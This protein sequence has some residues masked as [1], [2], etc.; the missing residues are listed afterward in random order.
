MSKGK[1]V[2][3]ALEITFKATW[4]FIF[5]FV[6]SF[7]GIRLRAQDETAKPPAEP[8]VI[9]VFPLGGQQGT[10]VEVE[11][12][13]RTLQGAYAIS[14]D[15]KGLKAQV[16]KVEEIELG[17][18]RGK[19]IES[20]K[21]P[22]GHRVL[23]RMQISPEARIG[24]YALW[25]IAARGVSNAV[26]FW[27][28]G[29]P[30]VVEGQEPNGTPEQAQALRLP[31][32]VNGKI[33]Q[34]GELDY[35]RF[36][37]TA[38]QEVVF[39]LISEM[40]I[41]SQLAL[42]EKAGS[43]F[44]PNRITQLAFTFDDDNTRVKP[45]LRYQFGKSSSFLLGVGSFSAKGCADCS[46]QI[47]IAP[48]DYWAFSQ[49]KRGFNQ[50]VRSDWRERDFNREIR[51]E[52]LQVLWSRTV[53]AETGETSTTA[54]GG[55]SSQAGSGE[56]SL[57]EPRVDSS[58]S[59]LTPSLI[60]DEEPN[61]T[62][63]QAVEITIPALIEGTI[64]RPEDVDVFKFKVKTGEKVAIE[65]QTPQAI[66]PHF[67]PRVGISETDG[68][69]FLTNIYKR[70][71][72]QFQ[73]YLKTVE[74]KTVYTF[75][76]GG[77][78]YLRIRDITSKYGGPDFVYRLLMRHQIPHVGGIELKEERVNLMPG[79]ARKLTLITEQEEGYSGEIALRVE[80]LPPG[81]EAFPGTEVEPDR[82][83][84]PDEGEKE[85]FVPKT[86]KATIVLMARADAPLT[87]QSHFVRIVGQPIIDGTP[88][89]P[90]FATL[91]PSRQLSQPQLPRRLV[92][93]QKIPLMVVSREEGTSVGTP[94]KKRETP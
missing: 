25:L 41:D 34:A 60:M 49:G 3:A 21:G 75:E 45:Q 52:R 23:V 65:L 26:P 44:D 7:P 29:D 73:F 32:V 47:R 54:S 56:M 55:S 30:V 67:N 4:V 53:R 88:G 57:T 81:V 72:R 6:I 31:V 66:P 19:E 70:L 5:F 33:S 84:N 91:A 90:L 27:V 68:N 17:S 18:K 2:L 50:V 76:L 85:R 38:G 16:E 62:I 39:E 22:R 94:P 10:V 36:E 46:Y 69:E 83:L 59:P 40:G 63:D 37:A 43:W 58:S 42:Y 8:E 80:K 20:E 64:D 74:P 87:T 48:K 1:P 71:G 9:S 92:E 86:Q 79:E 11:I 12:R 28:Q 13:G 77:E 82:G 61:D 78:Y 14:F 24:P 15:K 89:S 93:L 35:Y 51:L